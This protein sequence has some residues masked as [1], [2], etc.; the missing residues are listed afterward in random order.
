MFHIN[1]LL[2][3]AMI[4][5]AILF[6][7]RLHKQMRHLNG[8]L[9]HFNRCGMTGIKHRPYCEIHDQWMMTGWL[10]SVVVGGCSDELECEVQMLVV[11]H[12]LN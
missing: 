9:C 10:L 8:K 5:F 11:L 6:V 12:W 1:G 2:T 4:W 7:L 3:E